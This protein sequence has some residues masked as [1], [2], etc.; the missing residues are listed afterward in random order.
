MKPYNCIA[1]A[2]RKEMKKHVL[3][4]LGRRLSDWI[5]CG[6]R[7]CFYV[8]PGCSETFSS[9]VI[10]LPTV[11]HPVSIHMTLEYLRKIFIVFIAS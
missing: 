7:E 11:I 3:V 8:T 5:A 4:M 1:L 6:M 10:E 2:T 9:A